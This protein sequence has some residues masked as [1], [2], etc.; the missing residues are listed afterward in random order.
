MHICCLL[1]YFDDSNAAI[2]VPQHQ[3]HQHISVLFRS[4]HE[5]LH[6]SPQITLALL[7]LTQVQKD[8]KLLQNFFSTNI[9]ATTKVLAIQINDIH[10]DNYLTTLSI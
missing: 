6:I 9:T 1:E 7:S 5:Q 3:Q 8:L 4:V 10:I 2:A